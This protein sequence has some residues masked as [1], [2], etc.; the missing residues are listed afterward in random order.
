[1]SKLGYIKQKG[2]V[3][4]YDA[5]GKL[6]DRGHYYT[7]EG[8]EKIMEQWKEMFP[9]GAYFQIYPKALNIDA[10]KEEKKKFIKEIIEQKPKPKRHPAV[11]DN[12][13]WV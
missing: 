11:Y 6:L 13:Q 2:R 10:E 12:R 4:I 7:K 1:M 3:S 5:N 8:R 9:E